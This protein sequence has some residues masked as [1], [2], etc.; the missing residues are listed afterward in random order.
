MTSPLYF[1][2]LHTFNESCQESCTI[3]VLF[4]LI[5]VDNNTHIKSS[6]L[7][8]NSIDD[9]LKEVFFTVRILE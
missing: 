6:F 9:L 1:I 3:P 5:S 2:L 8:R 7:C 4:A